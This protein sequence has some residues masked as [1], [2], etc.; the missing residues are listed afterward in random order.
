MRKVLI[1]AVLCLVLVVSAVTTACAPAKPTPT[2][3][4]AA[5]TAPT[6]TMSATTA[7]TPTR[8][9]TAAPAVTPT[10]GKVYK[11]KYALPTARAVYPYFE[12]WLEEMQEKSGG[13]IQITVLEQGQHPYG[14]ADLLPAV[15]DRLVDMGY[16]SMTYASS[17]E[18]I[19][20]GLDLPMLLEGGPAEEWA[21]I[22]EQV[23]GKLLD[24]P[25][26]RWNTIALTP[27]GYA[28]WGLLGPRLIKTLDDMKGLKF[29]TVGKSQT[30]MIEA[31]G[32]TP[33]S[34]AW[35]DVYPGLQR[36]VID[37]L[38]MVTQAAYDAKL[39]EVIKFDT[40]LAFAHFLGWNL[41][42]K[43]AF[44]EL[45]ADLQKMMIELSD[46]HGK[47]FFKWQIDNDSAY[48]VKAM[49]NYGATYTTSS[50]DLRA[51]TAERMKPVWADW[52]KRAGPEGTA[53]LSKILELHKQWKASH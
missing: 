40:R 38:P 52:E 7:P 4:V 29:R 12:P 33:V 31:M 47:G 41:I 17:A 22:L 23:R 50:P 25:M 8:A 19:V 37:G 15:R 44:E 13:R 43:Q 1:S 30:A 16:N 10:P 21:W 24:E 2:P 28:G 18:P 34:L 49:D 26:A 32:G 39:Y 20:E 48:V 9:A 46:K 5:T 45:P 27:F 51:K 6:P 36:G 14:P 53:L 42:N 11:W 35:A 3:T